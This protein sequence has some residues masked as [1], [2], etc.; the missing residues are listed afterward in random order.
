[1]Y[2]GNKGL[3]N[4]GNTCYMNS[5]IQCLSHLLEFHPKNNTFLDQNRNNNDILV[6]W[7]KLQIQLWSNID[8]DIVIPKDFLKSFITNC[9]L[10]K[11]RIL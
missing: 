10:L 7:T 1:M 4:L 9:K 3:A 8:S 6:E 11:K 2:A 5:A